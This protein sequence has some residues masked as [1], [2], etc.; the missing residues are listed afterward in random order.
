MR[1]GWE[2]DQGRVIYIQCREFFLYY[3]HRI[4]PLSA[5]EK[6]PCSTTYS[7]ISTSM[8]QFLHIDILHVARVPLILSLP[9]SGIEKLFQRNGLVYKLRLCLLLN[10]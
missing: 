8:T 9:L 4:E 2:V 5:S 3:C 6:G 10:K 1:L 7:D